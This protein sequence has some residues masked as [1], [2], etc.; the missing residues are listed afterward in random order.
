MKEIQKLEEDGLGYDSQSN[1]VRALRPGFCT[2]QAPKR[3]C[4]RQPALVNESAQARSKPGLRLL[5]NVSSER[6]N[7][8]STC[9]GDGRVEVNLNSR[10]A[11]AL[12]KTIDAPTEEPPPAYTAQPTLPW[13]IM[14]EFNYP[15]LL[16]VEVMCSHLS[17]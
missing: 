3:T 10:L 4:L 12:S 15:R 5:F 16:A 14:L 8:I 11:R 1:L 6:P 17:H 2:M 9:L 13:Q 7:L